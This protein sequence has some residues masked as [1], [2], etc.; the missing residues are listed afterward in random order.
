MYVESNYEFPVLIYLTSSVRYVSS[1]TYTNTTNLAKL[2]RPKRPYRTYFPPGLDFNRNVET[3]G[4]RK[5][6]GYIVDRIESQ[7]QQQEQ[8]QQEG[9]E[10]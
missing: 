6:K 7:Q 5:N 3:D 10:R 4:I 9:T 8:Q 1:I 2:V